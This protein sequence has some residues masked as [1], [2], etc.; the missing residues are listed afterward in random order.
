ML[1]DFAECKRFSGARVT[2]ASRAK[3]GSWGCQDLA[4]C[5]QPIPDHGGHAAEDAQS[6]RNSGPFETST[7]SFSG[8]LVPSAAQPDQYLPQ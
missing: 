7:R 4:V 3:G 8:S 5:F 6:P 1:F 2:K